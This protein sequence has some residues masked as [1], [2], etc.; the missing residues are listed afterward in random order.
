MLSFT[1]NLHSIQLFFLAS[2][3]F[4][5]IIPC[6]PLSRAENYIECCAQYVNTSTDHK[7][8]PPFCL[9]WLQNKTVTC[10]LLLD[11]FSIIQSRFF[12][13]IILITESSMTSPTVIGARSPA[14]LAIQLVKDI[15]SPA[16]L[17]EISR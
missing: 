15:K 9:R 17:G 10:K 14:R 1:D 4:I 6:L 3:I 5:W 12:K 8:N 11:Q 7:Y 16:N 2:F 13:K